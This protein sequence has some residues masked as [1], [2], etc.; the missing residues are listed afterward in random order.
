MMVKILNDFL[1]PI[2]EK[3]EALLKRPDD[4]EDILRAGNQKAAEKARE[5]M[6]R[7]REAMGI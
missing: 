3:R 6:K 2:R 1:E 4:L 7:I 5:T